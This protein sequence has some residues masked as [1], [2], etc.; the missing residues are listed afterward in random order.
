MI[1]KNGINLTLLAI[2]FSIISSGLILIC[3]YL[4]QFV[5]LLVNV[6]LYG[7]GLIFSYDWANQYWNYSDLIR[8]SIFIFILITVLL[9]IFIIVQYVLPKNSVKIVNSI[10]YS[11]RIFIILFSIFS[12]IRLDSIINNSLYNYG[13]QFS[14]SWAGPYWN[15]LVIFFGLFLATI[16]F[17]VISLLLLI[18]SNSWFQK[19]LK[20]VINI[21]SM[22]FFIGLAI[23]FVSI[24]FNSSVLV[25]AGLGLVFWG[26]ILLYIRPHRYIKEDLLLTATKSSLKNLRQMILEL[27]YK[28]SGIYLPPKYLTDITSSKVFITKT[29]KL[30]LPSVK[31]IQNKNNVIIKKPEGL[32]VTPPGFDLS[33]L[34]EGTIGIKFIQKDLSFVEL[35][36][37]RII[38]DELEIAQNLEIEVTE[39][40]IHIEIENSLYKNMG[41]LS[42]AIACIIAK[43]SG[44]LVIIENRETR[45]DGQIIDLDF[46]LFESPAA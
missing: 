11:A 34:F 5:D 24:S 20:S 43:T 30:I 45:K 7:Y 25:F 37:R 46:R 6:D 10:L 19:N 21:N 1:K 41:T 35:N 22:L 32:L 26:A 4:L 3:Y 44:K 12:L 36:L 42:S 2:P 18:T 15:N 8:N 16:I 23:L 31:Q 17:D 38:V 39:D 28:G 29:S 40:I 33:I 13:L 14:Y 9:V 27:G